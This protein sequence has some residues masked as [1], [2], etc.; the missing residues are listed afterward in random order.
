M[1]GAIIVVFIFWG[2]GSFRARQANLLAKVNGQSITLTEFQRLYQQRL[3]QLQRMFRGQLNDKLLKQLN[4]PGQVFEELVRR[5]LLAQAAQKMGVTVTPDEVRLAI[6]Q[7]HVFQEKGRF[8]PER[9]RLILREMR[10]LPADFEAQVKD[11]LLEAKLRH[12]LTTPIVATTNEVKER[13]QFENEALKVGYVKLAVDDFAAQVKPTEAELKKYF[14]AHQEAYRTPLRLKLLYYLLPYDQIRREIKISSAEIKEYY[15]SHKEEF[16]RPEARKI[17]HILV[18]VKTGQDETKARDK[19]EKIL[20][21][22]KSPKDFARVAKKYSDDPH[23]KADGGELGYVTKKELFPSLQGPVFNAK[24]GEIIGPIRSPLGYHI[25]LVEKIRPKGYVPLAKVK[26]K[27]VAKLKDQKVKSL[28]WDKAN[29]A[30]DQIILL[31]GLKKW[32]AK[33]HVK[34]S[35]TPLFAVDTPPS[36]PIITPQVLKA[37]QK[38][39]EGEL[40]PPLEVPSGILIFKL[41]KRDDPHIPS[42][43]KVKAQVKA[44]YVAEKARELCRQKAEKLLALLR[45]GP[46][47]ELLQKQGLTLKETGFFK[48]KEA[49]EKSGLPPAVAQEAT[50]LGRKGQWLDHPVA[51]S[52]AFYLLELLDYKPADLKDFAKEK[53]A[54]KVR[55][56]QE[57]RNQAFIS[58]YEHLRETAE[59]KLYQKIPN[60]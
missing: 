30:Y 8:S 17:R 48:R 22:I 39:E 51:T 29:K 57:K 1:L 35:E 18:A 33:E 7:I 28:A 37:A 53:E 2:V 46:A 6:A 38:L 47:K 55:I 4:L 9:Y 49:L 16:A 27:I 58:W 19:A 45:K 60:P 21:K 25:I 11:Q 26:E 36:L 56:T 40:G 10:I 3:D 43:T 42:F 52:E 34:L 31:G 50:A 44:D 13:Y 23:S 41:A 54:L 20:A 12:L 32:A 5:V 14:Q 24:P 15:E 59:V